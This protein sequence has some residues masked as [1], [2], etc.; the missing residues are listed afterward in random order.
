MSAVRVKCQLVSPLEGPLLIEPRN[1]PEMILPWVVCHDQENIFTTICNWTD[2]DMALASHTCVGHACALPDTVPDQM[3]EEGLGR[4]QLSPAL[5]RCC[6]NLTLPPHVE[7]LWLES[8]V[9]LES[10]QAESLKKILIEY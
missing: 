2:H 9:D 4:L 6:S 1:S 8:Q 10:S 7:N 3:L 5:R